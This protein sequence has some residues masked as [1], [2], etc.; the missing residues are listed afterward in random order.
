MV[1][2]IDL[3]KPIL[4]DLRSFGRVNKPVRPWLGVYS[5]V[6][7]AATVCDKIKVGVKLT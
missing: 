3:L 2:P 4:D 5:V 6:S 1:V 7:C